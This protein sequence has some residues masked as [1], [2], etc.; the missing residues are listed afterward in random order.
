MTMLHLFHMEK[1]N[2]VRLEIMIRGIEKARVLI[3]LIGN[4]PSSSTP[5]GPRLETFTAGQLQ[6]GQ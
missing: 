3:E 5:A 6:F 2:E 4:T 1:S